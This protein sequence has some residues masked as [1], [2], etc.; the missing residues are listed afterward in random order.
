M[1]IFAI[2]LV[3]SKEYIYIYIYRYETVE[4]LLRFSII[5]NKS[6]LSKKVCIFNNFE[7]QYFSEL[8]ALI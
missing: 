4:Y 6:M 1:Y 2:L 5:G 8:L 7:I 3:Q